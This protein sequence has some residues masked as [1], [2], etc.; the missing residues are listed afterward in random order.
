MAPI[1]N[2][3]PRRQILATL[4]RDSRKNMGGPPRRASGRDATT[5][6]LWS[7]HRPLAYDHYPISD[8]HPTLA[9]IMPVMDEILSLLSIDRIRA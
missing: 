8:D 2:D 5:F 1:K 9:H 6:P 3:G 7:P 4:A